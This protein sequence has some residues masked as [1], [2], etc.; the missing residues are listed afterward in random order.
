LRGKRDDGSIRIEIENANGPIPR[1][2]VDCVFEPFFTTKPS[3]TGLGLAIARNIARGHG[4]EL[5]LSRNQADSVQFSITLPAY[6][7]ESGLF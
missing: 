1:D 6:T 2:A 3:G 7:G 5:V 4:G